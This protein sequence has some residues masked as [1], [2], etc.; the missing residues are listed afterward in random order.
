[1]AKFKT[2]ARAVDMLGRQQIAGVPNAIS[3]LFKN[4]HDAYADHVEVD[5]F[6]SDGLFVL[7][8][9]GLGM[10]QKDFED[11]W[12]VI[13][14]ESKLP[15]SKGIELPPVDPNKEPRPITGEKGIGRLAIAVI[16]PQVLVLTRAERKNKLDDLVASFIHWGL[17]EAPGV[18]LEQIDIPVKSFPGGTLPENKD[19]FALIDVVRENVKSLKKDGFLEGA[20][21]KKIT[22]DLDSFRVDL[23]E[24]ASVL[25]TPSLLDS[26]RGTQF[27]ICPTYENLNADLD[28]DLQDKEMSRLRKLLLGFTNTMLPDHR[29]PIM[30]AFRYWATDEGSQEMIGDREFFTPRDFEL[31]DHHIEGE[32]DE[33]GKFV[34]TVSVYDKKTFQVTVPWK[35]TKTALTT[36]GPFKI[37]VGYVQGRASQS[38]VPPLLHAEIFRKLNRIGGLYIYQ[39]DIRILPYGDFD[40]DFLGFEK[41]RSLQASEG[42]FSFRRMFGAIELSRERN[43]YLVEKAGR[44]GFQE[45]KAYR[46]FKSI[47]ENFF[48]QLTIDFFREGGRKADVWAE[49]REQLRRLV[50]ARKKQDAEGRKKRREFE[51][52]LDN[53]F[54]LVNTGEPQQDISS[55]LV[56]LRKKVDAAMKKKDGISLLDA[57]RSAT[58]ELVALRTNKYKV[59]LPQG[60]GVGQL[61]YDWS[62]Y[63]KEFERLEKEIFRPTQNDINNIVSAA[64]QGLKFEFDQKQLI[65][66]LVQDIIL[67]NERSIKSNI[68][69]TQ[70]TL[71]GLEDRLKKLTQEINKDLSQTSEKI[72]DELAELDVSDKDKKKVENYQYKWEARIAEMAKEYNEVLTH[73]R[74]QLQ[75]INWQRDES[76]YLIGNAEI[77]AALEDEVLDLRERL[78]ANLELTQLGMAV[79]IIN[80]EFTNTIKAIR[81]NIRLLKAWADRNP[82]LLPLYQDIND[83]F[84]HL[85]GYLTLFTP[86][87]RRLYRAA[88]DITGSNIAKYLK[89]LFKDRLERDE[90]E[91]IVT[92]AFRDTTVVGYPSTFYP[93]FIN[94]IDNAIFW[95]KDQPLP[96]EITLDAKEDTFIVC[97]NGPGVNKRDRDAVFEL[98]FTRKPGGRGMGLYISQE[99]LKREKYQ[100]SLLETPSSK[101][102]TFVIKPIQ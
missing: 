44:E 85:D 21:A 56:S 3:E 71:N 10:T 48:E 61:K 87:N 22:S 43:K 58:R 35:Q 39:D 5:Y 11:R 12:L 80:H 86:L 32:F 73:I 19:I 69:A 84:S 78:D 17:F 15:S 102:A 64:S 100:L 94:L 90:I 20:L 83:S 13:G 24:I 55:I 41:K 98:G 81:N 68:K 38:K 91:L 45:N 31:V 16:G 40:F 57:E 89:D 28:A 50:E 76:G 62:S 18:N 51:S 23:S 70:D 7:R 82:K 27:Y 66:L 92:K 65:D 74:T 30:T 63:V 95:L 26:G 59:E 101:G 6:R 75:N 77:M 54:S 4:A 60:V 53:F 46:E 47:L 37:T 93:V 33:F 42:F 67:E 96:R 79:D 8:D 36:C 29:V 49:T 99:V 1:M 25:G 97:D 2:R 9:D 72:K 34:G 52:Q 14:T 88:V